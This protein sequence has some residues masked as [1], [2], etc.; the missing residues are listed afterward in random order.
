[1][2]KN[3]CGNN[4]NLSIK[5]LLSDVK[6]PQLFY[7]ASDSTISIVSRMSNRDNILKQW[8]FDAN[9]VC[10]SYWEVNDDGKINKVGVIS[11]DEYVA[12][13]GDVECTFRNGKFKYKCGKYT[14]DV[15]VTD[16]TKFYIHLMANNEVK[17]KF[18]YKP[19]FD[20]EDTYIK[21]F[22]RCSD[23]STALI[24]ILSAFCRDFKEYLAKGDSMFADRP[25]YQ[26]VLDKVKKIAKPMEEMNFSAK[27]KY[28]KAE[29]EQY[30]NEVGESLSDEEF[31]MAGKM[32]RGSYGTM[33]RKYDPIGFEVG[34]HD[35]LREHNQ[36]SM[37]E[38][39][40][41]PKLTF[42]F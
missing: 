33:M 9:G 19:A 17:Y 41:K 27:R 30:L 40:R 6:N 8:V 32:R 20:D 2:K 16:K 3:V 26:M 36:W 25:T 12:N 37:S 38:N 7:R 31:I 1:M 21:F 28:S 15:D 5:D 39:K 23:G 22:E 14:I 24:S 29:Y 13:D 42:W 35:W 11:E 34:Y 18:T 4:K 10:Y